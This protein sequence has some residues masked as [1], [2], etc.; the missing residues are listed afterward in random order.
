M[1]TTTMTTSTKALDEKPDRTKR[2]GSRGRGAVAGLALA[3]LMIGAGVANPTDS[4]TPSL[5]PV[6]GCSDFACE[7]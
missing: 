3:G 1:K 4:G 7:K 6:S 2:R 5:P